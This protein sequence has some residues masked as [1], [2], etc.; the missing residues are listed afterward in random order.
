M[1]VI[2]VS[3]LKRLVGACGFEL[4]TPTVSTI[5]FTLTDLNNKG[6]F[7]LFSLLSDQLPDQLLLVSSYSPFSSSPPLRVEAHPQRQLAKTEARQ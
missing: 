7:L 3:S 1:K 2:R 5:R 6:P 4:Q